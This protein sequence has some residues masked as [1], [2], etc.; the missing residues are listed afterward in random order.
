MKTV[1]VTF[2]FG[3]EIIGSLSLD[4]KIVELLRATPEHCVT[5]AFNGEGSIDPETE[6]PLVP[7]EICGAAVIPNAS[8]PKGKYKDLPPTFPK[9]NPT[10]TIPRSL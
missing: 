9:P 7:W 10:G 6:R 8:L 2:N 1:P 4:E 5:F 3:E